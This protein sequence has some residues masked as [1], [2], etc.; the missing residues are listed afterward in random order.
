M[1]QLFVPKIIDTL[2]D[3]LFGKI[4]FSEIPAGGA[5]LYGIIYRSPPSVGETIPVTKVSNRCA[6]V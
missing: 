5:A 3:F 4:R 1:M 2:L 6:E